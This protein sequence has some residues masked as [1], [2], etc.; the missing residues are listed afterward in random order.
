MRTVAEILI[1]YTAVLIAYAAVL[2][3]YAAVLIA[4]AA[5]LIA[6]AGFTHTKVGIVASS[7]F[8]FCARGRSLLMT[9]TFVV[10][11][12]VG[13]VIRFS[14]VGG[15]TCVAVLLLLVVLPRP[16]KQRRTRRHG[17]GGGGDKFPA[18]TFSV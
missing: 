16:S 9:E 6:Y 13:V 5:V 17:V 12:N 4:Y 1:A 8:L 18:S 2:I 15:W 7:Y 3:A 10:P 11:I 14:V